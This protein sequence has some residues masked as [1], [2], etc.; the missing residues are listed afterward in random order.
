MA[1]LSELERDDLVDEILNS[2]DGTMLVLI[3]VND[4]TGDS[5]PLPPQYVVQM[6]G[7]RSSP[8]VSAQNSQAVNS[9]A[10]Q[11]YFLGK[12]LD[13]EVGMWFAYDGHKGGRITNVT[14]DPILG[15]TR[16]VGEIP[17]GGL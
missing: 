5:T 1:L 4:D 9:R 3:R 16:I 6:V 11:Y 15:L 8:L 2:Q 13:A 14:T 17:V 12:D 10:T 7:K